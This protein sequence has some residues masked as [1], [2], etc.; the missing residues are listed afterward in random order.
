MKKIIV[1]ALMISAT[2]LL[3]QTYIWPTDASQLLTS[4]FAEAR[5]GRF[6]AGIDIKTWGQTGYPI[7]AVRDGYVSRIQVSPFGYGRVL[8]QTLDTG[9]IVLYAHLERFGDAINAFV[10]SEQKRRSSYEIQLYPAAEQ[11]PVK[12]G[13]IIAY[14]G[15]SGVGF[16]HLHFEMRDANSNPINPFGRSYV[17]DDRIAPV[18]TKLLIQPMDALS[19][20]NGDCEP[21]VIYPANEGIGRYRVAQTLSVC[22]RI[23]FGVSIFDQMNGADHTFGI[24]RNELFVDDQLV[25]SSQYDHF[26]YSVNNQFNLDRDYRQRVLGNGYFYNLF[27]DVS[28]SLSFYQK[29]AVYYGVLDFIRESSNDDDKIDPDKIVTIPRGVF[30]VAGKEHSYL[31]RTSDYWGN[32]AELRG[33]LTV[34]GEHLVIAQEPEVDLD[35]ADGQQATDDVSENQSSA[36]E[37][38]SFEIKTRFYDRY[39]RITLT[40]NKPAVGAP[41]VQGKLCDEKRFT[42][43]VQKRGS[44]TYIGAWPLSECS[45]GPLLLQ[46]LATGARGDTLVQNERIDFETVAQGKSKV[47]RST[48]GLC[49]LSFNTGSLFKDL[50]VRSAIT[51]NISETQR[52][53]VG[54]LYSFD[55]TDVPLDKGATLTITYPANDSLPTKL[56]IYQKSGGSYYF[57]D[58]Q[59]NGEK[60]TLTAQIKNLGVYTLVRDTRPPAIAFLSPAD[61]SHSRL[62]QPKLRAS[63]GDNLSGIGGENSRILKLDGEKVIAEY[64]YEKALLFYQPDEPLSRGRHTVDVVVRDRSGN[65]SSLQHVFYID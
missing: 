16:P 45:Q 23:G 19:A 40:A 65:S 21:L 38:H 4:S 30:Q 12:Q 36:A 52:N 5:N 10:K 37:Q 60:R 2:R 6:H 33:K 48:D 17:V 27:R 11:F 39:I 13:D 43:P 9:E 49:S 64:D 8:Y 47:I 53:I 57:V 28:N 44:L 22:G 14:S 18:I 7:F 62:K 15:Q 46:I 51:D 59:L 54:A 58:N 1:L 32:T 35:G 25:F 3:P 24:Y 61:N 31:I 20:V 63:F 56:G 41:T 26:S 42:M 29:S 55:P 50:F 34:D